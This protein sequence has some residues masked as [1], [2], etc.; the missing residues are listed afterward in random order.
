MCTAAVHF[1]A[2]RLAFLLKDRSLDYFAH[3]SQ[4]QSC[5]SLKYGVNFE[6]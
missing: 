1:M 3:K 4:I 5:R 2:F 6:S